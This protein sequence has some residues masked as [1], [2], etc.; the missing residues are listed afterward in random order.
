M[1]RRMRMTVGCAE[2]DDW[3]CHGPMGRTWRVAE[4][5]RRRER[6]AVRDCRGGPPRPGAGRGR[7]ALTGRLA[8]LLVRTR[9]G[10]LPMVHGRPGD[11]THASGP[12]VNAPPGPAAG[13]GAAA[14]GGFPGPAP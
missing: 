9:A 11:G 3:S 2:Q 1:A 7:L 10:L 12:P 4:Q 14:W 5:G 13:R 6:G 8:A